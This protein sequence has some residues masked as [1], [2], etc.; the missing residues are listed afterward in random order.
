M[1]TIRILAAIL[2]IASLTSCIGAQQKAERNNQNIMELRL[3]MPQEQVLRIMGKPDLKNYV[4][5]DGRSWVILGYYTLPL[6]PDGIVTVDECTLL[7]FEDG[8]LIKIGW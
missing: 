1:K 5:Q 8:V 4:H 2:L 3:G 6:K 7:G